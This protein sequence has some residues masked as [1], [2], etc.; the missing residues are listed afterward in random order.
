MVLSSV[1]DMISFGK[2]L[3]VYNVRFCIKCV[4]YMPESYKNK[5]V[6]D[7]QTM[8]LFRTTYILF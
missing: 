2:K 3:L 6:R 7:F 5:I 1:A 8:N 4:L